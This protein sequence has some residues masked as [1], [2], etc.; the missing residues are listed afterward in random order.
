M[1]H[2][3]VLLAA[4]ALAL[5]AASA[6]AQSPSGGGPGRRMEMLFQGIT[7]TSEQRAKVDSI[8]KHYREQMPSLT[9]GTPPDSATRE[10]I[11][12]L[13]RHQADDIRAVL[14]PEQQSVF[15]KNVAA[16]RARRAGGP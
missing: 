9:P 15:D 7:L 13:L 2:H 10:K 4:A 1:K 12:G 14:T 6:R 3:L 8:Q 5:L 16:M 11:R